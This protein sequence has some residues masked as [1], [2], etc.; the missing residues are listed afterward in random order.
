MN[1]FFTALLVLGL[2]AANGAAHA[3]KRKRMPIP[4]LPVSK[5]ELIRQEAVKVAEQSLPRPTTPQTTPAR[6]EVPEV[7][8][9]EGDAGLD[10]FM[11]NFSKTEYYYFMNAVPV[12]Y[13]TNT[14]S[15]VLGAGNRVLGT[16]DLVIQDY[17]KS[18]SNLKL[19]RDFVCTTKGQSRVCYA[20]GINHNV[21]VD[22]RNSLREHCQRHGLTA[23]NLGML[24]LTSNSVTT[25]TCNQEQSYTYTR[26]EN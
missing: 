7:P 19:I 5:I 23:W 9:F 15:L 6:Q 20:Q 8:T 4:P 25:I 2:I 17:K 26:D 21:S 24:T 13:R 1:Q 10:A 14:A 12:G 3:K 18:V 11:G 22:L 16:F